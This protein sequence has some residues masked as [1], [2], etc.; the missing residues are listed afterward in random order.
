MKEA[1]LERTDL[2]TRVNADNLAPAFLEGLE[3]LY[4]GTRL[5][6]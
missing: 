2:P 4:G 3:G 1:G 5:A 6:A